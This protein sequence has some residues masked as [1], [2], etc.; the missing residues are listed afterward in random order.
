[1][2]REREVEALAPAP[3]EL[4]FFSLPKVQSK[5]SEVNGFIF[6]CTR[7][8]VHN[9]ETLLFVLFTTNANIY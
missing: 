2:A 1:M 5:Q 9:R 4:C 7:Q 3:H 6:S 8:F